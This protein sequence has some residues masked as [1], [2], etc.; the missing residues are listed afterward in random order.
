MVPT[1]HEDGVGT[2]RPRGWS[3]P[4]VLRGFRVIQF[5]VKMC[6]TKLFT[7]S[8]QKVLVDVGTG[9]FCQK[10]VADASK[11]LNSKVEMLQENSSKV[12][13]L[14]K[15]KQAVLEEVTSMLMSYQKQMGEGAAPSAQ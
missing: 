15:K 3:G 8:P 1:N 4:Q 12:A 5:G 9:Y 2:A 7:I 10:N 11:F 6:L 13:A 14:V